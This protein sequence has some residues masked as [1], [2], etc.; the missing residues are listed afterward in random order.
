MKD[1]N[2]RIAII[3]KASWIALIGNGI[4]SLSKII[5]GLASGSLSVLSD[6]IDSATDVF[7]ATVTLFAARISS[8]PGD[9]EH[10][11]GHGRVETVS[12]ALISFIVFFAGAQLLFSAFKGI[13]S[14]GSGE[15][16]SVFALW[17]TAASV[18]G[19]SLLAWSQFYYGKKS[20]SSMLIA[21]GKNMRGDI[22]TSVAVLLGL[23]ITYIT[24][25]SIMDKVFAA[26]VSLWIIKNAV[27]IF[28]EAN[29]ELMDGT[30]DHGPYEDIFNA[31]D[32]IPEAIHP[33]KVRLRKVGAMLMV[34]LDIEVDETLSVRQ[35]H[36]IAISVEAAIKQ[37]LPDVYD[38]IVH[39]EP[40]GNVEEEKFG[41]SAED[42]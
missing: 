13:F 16:P 7:I 38:V 15:L 11:Y 19:K 4:L 12:A 3:R 20:N 5:A 8:K 37:E 42:T 24:G 41:L 17:I 34:D 39:V 35:A 14:E 21:N 6:G 40:R 25:I 29:T 2:G 1:H 33:H 32:T 23:A 27:E 31:L 26:L 18:I 36:T 22:V 30:Q 28:I 10:P 9:K